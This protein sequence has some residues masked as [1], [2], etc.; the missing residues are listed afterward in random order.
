MFS[1]ASRLLGRGQPLSVVLLLLLF[2]AM[3]SWDAWA[4]TLGEGRMWKEKV[5]TMIHVSVKKRPL[6]MP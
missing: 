6:V 4:G 3:P 5:R 2:F 1:R